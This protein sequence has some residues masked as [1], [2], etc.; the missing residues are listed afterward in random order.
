MADFF[1]LEVRS[2]VTLNCSTVSICVINVPPRRTTEALLK[3]TIGLDYSARLLEASQHLQQN[4]SIYYYYYFRGRL[5]E[6]WTSS[7]SVAVCEPL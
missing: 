5:E 2:L 1:H 7:S 4:Y 6:V 3:K